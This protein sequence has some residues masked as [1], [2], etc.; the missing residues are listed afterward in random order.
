[1]QRSRITGF[2]YGKQAVELARI[3]QA[4]GKAKGNQTRKPYKGLGRQDL[5]VAKGFG[6]Q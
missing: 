1:M 6:L 5:D 3:F 4:E 2:V